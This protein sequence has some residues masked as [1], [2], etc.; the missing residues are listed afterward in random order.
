MCGIAGMLGRPE[1]ATIRRMLDAQRHRGPDGRKIWTVP[2]QVGFGHDRLAIID[3]SGGDQPLWNEDGTLV[4]IVNGEIY[5]HKALRRELQ[6]RHTFRTQSDSEVVLHLYEEEGPDFVRRLDGMFAIA[7]WGPDGLFLARDPLGIKPLYYGRDERGSLLFA[8]E[9]KSLL[10][11]VDRISELPPGTYWMP[12]NS[13]VRYYDVPT[14]ASQ[15]ADETTAITEIDHLLTKAISKRLMADVPLGVFLSGGLDSSLI[16]AI[17]AR[18]YPGRLRSFS[19]GL[20]GSADVENARTMARF[21]NTDHHERILT[22]DEVI[23]AVPK[24]IELLE[25]CDPALVRSAIPTYYVSEL[26]SR[27]VKVVLSGEGADE[28]FA[29]Y[30]YLRGLD[31]H[32]LNTELKKITSELHNLNLQRVDRMTMAHG[33]EGRVPFLDLSMVR[34]A[35]R[36]DPALKWRADQGKWV[37]RKMAE[38]YLPP[39]IA[40]RTKEK[41]AIGTGIGQT[42]EQHAQTLFPGTTVPDGWTPESWWYWSVFGQQLYDRPDLI[43]GMGHSRSLNPEQ[44]WLSKI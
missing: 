1:D 44:R 3:V 23:G 28:L 32:E 7:I 41:F 17:A 14:P 12:E 18:E 9:P 21:L 8:S 27:H 33:L 6:Q 29:G 40:W 37:L 34:C 4:A 13:P 22:P 19:V 20:E 5:N 38:K 26:A 16:A 10:A 24:V 36:V 43:A 35:F 15:V 42:L 31:S 30:Q 39:E 25:S 2:D 11:E